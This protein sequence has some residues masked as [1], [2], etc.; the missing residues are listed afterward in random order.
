MASNGRD[1][2]AWVPRFLFLRGRGLG[3]RCRGAAVVA[4]AATAVAAG[5]AAGGHPGGDT[6]PS[7]GSAT[8]ANSANSPTPPTPAAA[9]WL[10]ATPAHWSQLVDS[11]ATRPFTVTHGLTEFSETYGTV[12]GGQHTQV[13]RAD[14]A[15][16][17]LRV[18]VVNSHDRV[19][20]PPNETLSSMG[21]RTGAVAGVNGD[22]FDING[23]GA[24]RGGVIRHG[25]VVKSPTPDYNPQLAVRGNGSMVIGPQNYTG[26]VSDGAAGCAVSSVNTLDDAAAGRLTHLTA[27]L[28]AASR[29]PAE[30]L[31]IGHGAPAALVVDTVRT[32]ATAVP[33]LTAGQHGL[34]G[35][36]AGGAWLATTVHPGDTLRLAE[37]VGSGGVRELISGADVLVRH[38]VQYDDPTGRPPGG[39]S[40]N[41]NPE[42]AVGLSADGRHALVVTMDGLPSDPSVAGMTPGEVTGYFLAH[43]VDSAILF[44]GGGSTELVA[45]RPGGR[46]LSVLNVPCDGHERTIADG[47]FFFS[48]ATTAGSASRV[49]V[50]SGRPAATVVGAH[51]AVPAYATDALGNPAAGH[52]AVTVRPAALASYVGGVLTVHR[53]GSGVLTARGGRVAASVRLLVVDRL[54]ALTIS[55]AAPD[56]RNGAALQLT[57]AGRAP[58]AAAGSAPIPAA[59]P[60]AVAR[61]TVTPTGLG[62]VDG[63][64]RF[65]AAGSGTGLVTVTARAGGRSASARIA[66]GGVSRGV[67]GMSDVD[68]WTLRNGTGQPATFGAAP[69]VVPPRSTATG[70]LR[71]TYSIPAGPGV[72]RLA[73]SPKSTLVATDLGGR[74]P[75]GIG[76]WIRGDGN[77]VDLVESYVG[78]DGRTRTIW[79][80]AVSWRGWRFVVAPLPPGVQFPMR[81]TLIS[82][83]SL[84]ASHALTGTLNVSGLQVLYSPRPVAAAPYVPVPANPPWLRYEETAA[85][86]SP[87]GSTLLVG[88]GAHLL[89]TA[90]HSAGDNALA[91]VGARLPTLP[92]QARPERAQL[93][94]DSSGGGDLAD[95]Q[96]AHGRLAALGVPYR[97][98]VGDDEIGQGA[99]PE[100]DHFAAVFGDTSYTYPLGPETGSGAGAAA[101]AQVIVLDSAHG[102]IIASDRYQSPTLSGSQFPWLVDQLSRSTARTVIVATHLPAY[103][104]RP[105]GSDQFTDRW[106]AREFL[107]LIQRYQVSHPSRHVIIVH[108]HADGFTERIID[109]AG[110]PAGLGTGGTGTGGGAGGVP[111]LTFAGLDPAGDTPSGP[112]GRGSRGDFPQVGLLHVTS[113]GTVQFTVEPVLASLAVAAP[114]TVRAGATVQLTAAGAIVTSGNGGQ[115]DASRSEV[116]A[117]TVPIADPASHLWSSSDPRIASINPITGLLTARRPGTVQVTVTSG[118][119]SDRRTVTITR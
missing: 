5:V 35:G 66:V 116:G 50:N 83:I 36:G 58:G 43:G 60:A 69:G 77:G 51:V 80:A 100:T 71:L 95:L 4:L 88:G 63:R 48:T 108:G 101:A 14:L 106:E 34:L 90:P 46:R 30:T 1:G 61:W 42:T 3:P 115:G 102:G 79:P 6:Q 109:P 74:Q 45:R 9:A 107:R 110:H 75:N 31:V 85:A 20:D 28:G 64:G 38:G 76:L 59:V 12:S 29:L 40:P 119:R 84:S 47:L 18:G 97:D 112:G 13:L 73:L 111:E 93:L 52:L 25:R 104:P 103:D 96:Y 49:V 92:V 72:T 17:N 89:A 22:Y 98:A 7:V 10:P 87:T 70:S 41:R 78:T 94:G 91:A 37:Q 11:G 62:T 27:D 16:P 23:T 21:D 44:D 65:V 32:A 8:P 2:G 26:T 53:A 55:P 68:G 113:A 33:A 15:D 114:A 99:D 67:N 117:G 24:P 57:L 19:V 105:G 39:H 118:G 56:L 54:R 81:I 86:F 82:F